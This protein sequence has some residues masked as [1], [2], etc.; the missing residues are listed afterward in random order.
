MQKKALCS[1]KTFL[2]VI[3]NISK[4]VI[5]T[6]VMKD[7]FPPMLCSVR[8]FHLSLQHLI[9]VESSSLPRAS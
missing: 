2:P 3:R 8:S 5:I 9:D 7:I 1:N 6:E 4:L